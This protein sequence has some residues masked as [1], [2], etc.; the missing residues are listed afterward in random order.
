MTNK[1]VKLFD[2]S[3]LVGLL[4]VAAGIILTWGKIYTESN[5][6]FGTYWPVLIIVFG[7]GVILQYRDFRNFTP[8]GIITLIGAAILLDKLNVIAIKQL[9]P[10]AIIVVGLLIIFRKPVVCRI[11]T[12]GSGCSKVFGD[13]DEEVTSDH[14]DINTVMGGGKYQFTSKEL[15]GGEISTVMGSIEVD[16]RDAEIDGESAAIE[17][18]AVMSSIQLFLP[19]HWEV[20]VK[21]SPVLGSLDNR[22]H[23]N[24]DASKTI[25]INASTVMGSIE[26]RN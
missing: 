20:K 7:L 16:L 22:C 10:V 6:T 26:I 24:K 11:H 14:L 15:K 21:G 17:A 12:T 18:S 4:I 5:V 3:L 2:S 1:K 8:G 25:F 19:T 13:V 23:P 9:W